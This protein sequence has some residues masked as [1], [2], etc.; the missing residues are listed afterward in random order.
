MN[1][2]ARPWRPAALLALLAII[3]GVAP[4]PA[5]STIELGRLASLAT[6]DAQAVDELTPQSTLHPD[7]LL[8]VRGALGTAAAACRRLGDAG[9][10]THRQDQSL[11]CIEARA[12]PVR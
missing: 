4:L 5:A 6:P 12:P 11:G 10:R 8:D 2:P 1:H 9:G 3:M 7:P